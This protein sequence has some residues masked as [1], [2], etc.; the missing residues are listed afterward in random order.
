M[1]NF[2]STSGIIPKEHVTGD[3]KKLLHDSTYVIKIKDCITE[4]VQD[5]QNTED[6]L[7][8]DIMKYNFWCTS[9]QYVGGEDVKTKS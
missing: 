8:F 3:M 2:Y 4:I 6:D 9:M 7:L 1:L 5:N